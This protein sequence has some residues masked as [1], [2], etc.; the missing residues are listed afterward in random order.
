VWLARQ[1][2]QPLAFSGGVGLGNDPGPTEA[3]IARRSA[4]RDFGAR[5]TWIDDQSR[6]TNENAIRSVALLG[7]EGVARIVLVTHDFHM[8][9]ALAA[10]ERAIARQGHKIAL[11]GAPMGQ[12]LPGDRPELMDFLP[13]AEGLTATRL[14]LHEWLGRLAG[15]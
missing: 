15:A 7:A 1:T 8:S 10:F 9:R 5:I 12:R 13:S 14:A 4:A 11:V 2:G 6:D 3:E